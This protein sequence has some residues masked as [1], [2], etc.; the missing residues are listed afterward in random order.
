MN[1][2]SDE[3]LKMAANYLRDPEAQSALAKKLAGLATFNLPPVDIKTHETGGTGVR[4]SIPVRPFLSKG[5]ISTHDLF[6]EIMEGNTIT[7]DMKC[8]LR[9]IIMVLRQ[10]TDRALNIKDV[11]QCRLLQR[12]GFITATT[13]ITRKAVKK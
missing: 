9:T 8:E 2:Y 3:S 6:R 12:L 10:V 1:G 11:K 4:A 5:P 13:K 7:E